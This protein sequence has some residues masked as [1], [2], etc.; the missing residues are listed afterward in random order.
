ML[1]KTF[2]NGFI[3]PTPSEITDQTLYM[4]RRV[5]LQKM[6]AGMAGTALATWASREAFAQ[7]T[8]WTASGQLSKLPRVPSTLAGAVSMEKV[9]EYKHASYYNNFYEFGTD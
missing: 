3:H 7:D 4:R 2:Q 5:I 1:L 8:T 6:A 9:T